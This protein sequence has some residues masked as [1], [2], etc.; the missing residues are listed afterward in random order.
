MIARGDLIVAPP[1]CSDSQFV[2]SVTLLTDHTA[3]GS[4]GLILNR[5][6]ELTLNELLS[7]MD[8]TL[9][10]QHQLYWGGPQ[11]QDMVF[12]LHSSEW[13]IN[14]V[15]RG[16]DRNWSLTAHWSMFHHLA[17]HDEPQYWRVF[18]GC[19]AWAPEQLDQEIVSDDPGLSRLPINRPPTEGLLSIDGLWSW[20]ISRATEQAVSGLLI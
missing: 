14:N 4:R 17:D 13:R 9:P 8:I 2:K 7:P 3:R 18:A 20:A 16:I 12:M 11:A 19:A 15:T 1:R 10:W 6:T 5:A